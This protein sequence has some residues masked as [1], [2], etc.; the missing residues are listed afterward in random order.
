MQI[1]K[2]VKCT[3]NGEYMNGLDDLPLLMR[4]KQGVTLLQ[5]AR[6]VA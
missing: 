6:D 5:A 2:V 1:D 3:D 4:P